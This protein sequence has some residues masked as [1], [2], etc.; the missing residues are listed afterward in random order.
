MGGLDA[1]DL[2]MD[3]SFARPRIRLGIQ[4]VLFW[5]KGVC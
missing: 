1:M 3:A 5:F 2:A 4:R